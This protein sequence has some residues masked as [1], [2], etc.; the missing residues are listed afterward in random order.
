[1]GGAGIFPEI[2]IITGFYELSDEYIKAEYLWI[3]MGISGS[4]YSGITYESYSKNRDQEKSTASDLY[5]EFYI[6]NSTLWYG[7]YA[8]IT[9]RTFEQAAW[10]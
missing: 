4:D 7:S 2:F 3:I 8:V 1:M 6:C 9:G 5:A 10:D